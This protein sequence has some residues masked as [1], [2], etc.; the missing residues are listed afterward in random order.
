[1]SHFTAKQLQ[2]LRSQLITD[3]RDIEHRLSEN[4]H[5]GLGDSLKLQTG[6]LSP[7]DNHPGDIATE[8]YEREK[9][10]SLLEHDEFQLERI[11][12]ALHSIEEGHYGT[13]AVCQQPIPYE[14]MEAVPYTK[15]CKNTNRKPLSPKTVLS[16]KNSLPPHLDERVWMNGM[17]KMASMVRTPGRLLRAGAHRTH[18]RWL[19][20]VI[21]TAMTLWRLKPQMKWKV[22]LKRTKVLWQR[23]STVMTSPSYA[24]G[25]IAST[26]RTVKA[27][28]C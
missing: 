21:S 15:Y 20:D 16:R 6:E 4:E 10:I 24:I 19:K 11:D 5:Y 26:W 28:V 25:N 8:V 9:D 18:Q 17:T 2:F 7:I 13:C 12:S 22:A 27:M 14:R 23:I 3:K 1:M